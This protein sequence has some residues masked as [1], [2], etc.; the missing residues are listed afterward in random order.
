[1]GQQVHDLTILLAH[2]RH[3]LARGIKLAQLAADVAFNEMEFVKLL[4]RLKRKRR[5]EIIV[6]GDRGQVAAARFEKG[7]LDIIVPI[8]G[9]QDAD[10][11]LRLDETVTQGA[12]H[13]LISSERPLNGAVRT[14]SNFTHR[15]MH[16]ERCHGGSSS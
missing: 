14:G 3:D 15:T 5:L 6:T 13:A 12:N 16:W 1:M 7:A 8:D 10:R 4:L 9:V 11:P 2:A